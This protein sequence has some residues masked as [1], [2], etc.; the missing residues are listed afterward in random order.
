[1][2]VAITHTKSREK[3]LW[4]SSIN[5]YN[6]HCHGSKMNVA[7]LSLH[8]TVKS[9]S[10]CANASKRYRCAPASATP[11]MGLEPHWPPEARQDRADIRDRTYAK[12]LHARHPDAAQYWRTA[13]R[14]NAAGD[15][16]RK[17]YQYLGTDQTRPCHGPG[18]GQEAH[19][20]RRTHCRTVWLTPDN[21]NRPVWCSP[22]S[23]YPR[24]LSQPDP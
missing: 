18:A 11:G 16:L 23:M 21:A 15:V 19:R 24:P 2:L 10:A 8:A 12:R 17:S 13:R 3:H 7:A 5:S 4:R 22:Q 1:M 6:L 14:G 20:N 9:Q